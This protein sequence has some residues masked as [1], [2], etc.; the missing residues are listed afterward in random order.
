MT[1]HF[2]RDLKNSNI[3]LFCASSDTGNGDITIN[4]HT[5]KKRVRELLKRLLNLINVRLNILTQNVIEEVLYLSSLRIH[6]YSLLSQ[7]NNN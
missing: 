4:E 7:E 6:W 5:E 2:Q 1:G 3:P